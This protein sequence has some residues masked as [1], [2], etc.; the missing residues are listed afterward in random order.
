[1]SNTDAAAIA[2]VDRLIAAKAAEAEATK[3]RVAIEQEIIA[4]LGA[5]E[6][7]AET[8]D[9]S[10]GVKVVIAGKLTYSVAPDDM[11]AFIAKCEKLDAAI[12]PVKTVTMIDE[13]KAKKIRATDPKAWRC[14]GG[15]ITTKAA[16]TA[17]SIK[18]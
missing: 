4:I 11:P 7:G 17:V 15:M 1:M 13:T 9:L 2:L 14:I 8:H 5:K 6:E 3:N 16:K 10:N 12:A 18:A